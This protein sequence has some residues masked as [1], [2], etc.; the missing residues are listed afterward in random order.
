MAGRADSIS[1]EQKNDLCADHRHTDFDIRVTSRIQ[2][3]ATLKA[4]CAKV[5]SHQIP[6]PLL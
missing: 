2:A 3:R 1:P 6:P 4:S 5:H